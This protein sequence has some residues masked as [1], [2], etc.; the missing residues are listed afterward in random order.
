MTQ[1]LEQPTP[2]A[3]AAHHAAQ[4]EQAVMEAHAW[5]LEVDDLS[6]GRK[7]EADVWSAKEILGHLMDAASH[8]HQRFVRA[9]LEDGARL[10]GYKQ[11]EWVNLAAYQHRDWQGLVAFWVASHQHLWQIV[12]RLSDAQLEHQLFV[13]SRQIALHE[14]IDAYGRHLQHHLAQIR[15]RTA[16]EAKHA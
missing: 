12:A 1:L 4:L 2:H 9:A 11:D 7:P 6:A 14:L 13:G 16:P 10:P 8:A 3:R 5:L 15:Q